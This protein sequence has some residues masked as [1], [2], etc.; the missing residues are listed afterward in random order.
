ME[1]TS[2]ENNKML[3]CLKGVSFWV[4]YPMNGITIANNTIELTY[5]R[6][7]KPSIIAGIEI[8][9]GN[10]TI[11]SFQMANNAPLSNIV[12]ADNSITAILPDTTKDLSAGMVLHSLQKST[13]SNN[14]ISGV[15]YGGLLLLGSK[16]G[17]SKL[18]ITKNKF[19]DFK[20]GDVTKAVGG[21]VI[22]TDTYSTSTTNA[23]GIKDV[24]IIENDFLGN[25]LQSKANKTSAIKKKNFF[26]AFVALPEAM[27]KEIHFERNNFSDK[28]EKINFLKTQ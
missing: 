23:P 5:S 24:N 17:T 6:L 7:L 13:I 15:N 22:I 4:N 9:N 28:E 14:I 19:I 2:V 16:W 18:M 20:N 1:K 21:Y 12:I 8:P 3:Q 26:G 10:S 25:N 11:Y 27:H